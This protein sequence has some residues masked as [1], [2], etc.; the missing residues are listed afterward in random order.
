MLDKDLTVEIFDAYGRL[1]ENGRMHAGEMK[2]TRQVDSYAN[3]IYFVRFVR[4]NA[5]LGFGKF[6][7][8]D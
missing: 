8:R 6:V 4:N 7:V 3:G 5:V 1:V 2:L